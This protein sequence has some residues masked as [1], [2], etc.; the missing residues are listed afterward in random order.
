MK[1]KKSKLNIWWFLIT[2]I[3]LGLFVNL[4]FSP[5]QNYNGQTY[6]AFQLTYF[7]TQYWL[8]YYFWI[9]LSFMLIALMSH[10]LFL[11]FGFA[12]KYFLFL[13]LFIL[14]II[15]L[16]TITRSSYIESITFVK[17]FVPLEFIISVFGLVLLI[18][19]ELIALLFETPSKIERNKYFSVLLVVF[20]FFTTTTLFKIYGFKIASLFIVFVIIIK[21]IWNYLS[22]KKLERSKKKFNS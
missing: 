15:L 3:L 21:F 18:I 9:I 11:F 12:R 20:L 6:T 14:G 5:S 19:V 13:W 8:F 22:R 16:L 17:Y 4:F 10:I 7:M 1:F 2:F